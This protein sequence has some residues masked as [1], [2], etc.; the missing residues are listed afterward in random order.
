[1]IIQADWKWFPLI[2]ITDFDELIVLHI[3]RN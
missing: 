2:H 1:M 3:E